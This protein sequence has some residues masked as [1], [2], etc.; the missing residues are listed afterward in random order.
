VFVTD[1]YPTV[2]DERTIPELAA[3]AESYNQPESGEAHVTTHVIGLGVVDNLT[4]VAEA[5]GTGS[6]FFVDNA[7]GTPAD[8]RVYLE[9]IGSGQT[10]CEFNQPSFSGGFEPGDFQIQLE[11]DEMLSVIPYVANFQSCGATAGWYYADPSAPSVVR[12][13]PSLCQSMADGQVSFVDGCPS[14]F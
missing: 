11:E 6:G 1:G 8:A 14:G 10:V 9:K 4:S 2:C 7:A 3:L 12:L 13:C 5:G